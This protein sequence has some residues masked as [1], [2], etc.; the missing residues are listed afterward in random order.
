MANP[1]KKRDANEVAFDLVR[2]AT[3]PD[4]SASEDEKD[5]DAVSRGK[6]RAKSLTPEERSEIARKAARARWRESSG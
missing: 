1:R 6:A 5:P 2:K 4:A 3:D